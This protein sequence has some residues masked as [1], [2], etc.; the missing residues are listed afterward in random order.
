MF[1]NVSITYIVLRQRTYCHRSSL[2]RTEAMSELI[3]HCSTNSSTMLAEIQSISEPSDTAALK[4]V[5][6]FEH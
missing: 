3:R 4:E 6:P 5:G 2:A 1:H